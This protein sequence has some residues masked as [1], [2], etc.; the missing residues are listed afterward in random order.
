MDFI[1]LPFR[2]QK[3]TFKKGDVVSYQCKGEK[4]LSQIEFS[5]STVINAT[6]FGLDGKLPAF[7]KISISAEYLV[8]MLLSLIEVLNHL[9]AEKKSWH[10]K[11]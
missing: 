11:H 10:M 9:V 4:I 2:P 5:S 8:S 6:D 1:P 3:V 7:L